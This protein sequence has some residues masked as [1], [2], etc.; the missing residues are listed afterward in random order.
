MIIFEGGNPPDGFVDFR[1]GF[2]EQYFLYAILNGDLPTS[3]FGEA[4]YSDFSH[5]NNTPFLRYVDNHDIIT[6]GMPQKCG[7]SKSNQ[8][9]KI[10]R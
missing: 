6:D 7:N 8:R 9:V 3:K 1:Y 5:K 10:K 2:S 4:V